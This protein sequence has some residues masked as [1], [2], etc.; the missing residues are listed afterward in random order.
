[1]KIANTKSMKGLD[2]ARL[3]LDLPQIGDNGTISALYADQPYILEKHS[4][5]EHTDESR[6]GG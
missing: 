3:K 4:R 1:M 5:D 2:E 6:K